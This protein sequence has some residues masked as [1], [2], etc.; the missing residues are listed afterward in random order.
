[1][2][3]GKVV[4]A[5]ETVSL[6][7]PVEAGWQCWATANESGEGSIEAWSGNPNAID[8]LD[9][10][11]YAR[12]LVCFFPDV[13]EGFAAVIQRCGYLGPPPGGT[14]REVTVGGQKAELVEYRAEAGYLGQTVSGLIGT[15]VRD[16]T[17]FVIHAYGGPGSWEG[18]LPTVLQI[19]A[20]IEFAE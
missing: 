18:F 1:M 19:L 8:P 17:V 2:A 11:S 6:V 16:G 13:G 14:R 20:S 4:W 10:E 15:V 12:L 3:E 5:G 7:C 9:V